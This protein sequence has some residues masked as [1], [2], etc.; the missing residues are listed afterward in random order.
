MARSRTWK[1]PPSRRPRTSCSLADLDLNNL[2]AR[3]IRNLSS[4]VIGRSRVVL[5]TP[6]WPGL[7]AT[8]SNHSTHH[9]PNPAIQLAAL[10][11]TPPY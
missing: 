2:H 3:P 5:L 11:K 8:T 1:A 6:T 4:I 10:P 7:Y 9:T